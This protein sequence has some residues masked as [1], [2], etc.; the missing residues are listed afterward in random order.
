M[1]LILNLVAC[2]L[3]SEA[4]PSTA[5]SWNYIV[6]GR[7]RPIDAICTALFVLVLSRSQGY[8]DLRSM[9]PAVANE[10]PLNWRLHRFKKHHLLLNS[11][12]SAYRLWYTYPPLWRQ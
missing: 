3:A 10:E 9:S 2:C 8:F 4:C 1:I 12:V 7:S 5:C 6:I 11:L